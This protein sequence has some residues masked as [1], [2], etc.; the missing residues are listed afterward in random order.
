MWQCTL[1]AIAACCRLFPSWQRRPAPPQPA[2]TSRLPRFG[3][4]P[5]ALQCLPILSHPGPPS[6]AT[7]LPGVA[8]HAGP[9]QAAPRQPRPRRPPPLAPPSAAPSA[10]AAGLPA[11]VALR[12]GA[13]PR[14]CGGVAA[15]GAAVQPRAAVGAA[16]G[17]AVRPP[18]PGR[19]LQAQHARR[20]QV[21]LAG[22]LGAAV[23]EAGMEEERIR[24]Q[25]LVCSASRHGKAL[26]A[27]HL[28]ALGRRCRLEG[29][30]VGWR[31]GWRRPTHAYSSAF[32]SSVGQS[33]AA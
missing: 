15:L 24:C 26:V 31:R 7:H 11:A 1:Q 25:A 28:V 16:A 8:E 3:C 13:R 22:L 23:P 2:P 21:Q 14:G 10:P 29:Y 32:W 9:Q 18:A 27:L 17:A 6:P 4:V 5:S 20:L 12:G 19:Q 33:R 30:A